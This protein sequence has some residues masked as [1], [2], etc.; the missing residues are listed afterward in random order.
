[1]ELL[2]TVQR[3]VEHDRVDLVVLND[4]PPSLGYRVLRDGVPIVV[5]DEKARIAHWVSTV[6]RYLDM[7]PFRETFAAGLRHQLA[8]GRFG[9]R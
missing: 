1:L 9:R 5:H 2:D 6:D 7:A 8:E 4:A 3:T